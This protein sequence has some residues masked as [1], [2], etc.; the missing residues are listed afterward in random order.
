MHGADLYSNT[1]FTN[2]TCGIDLPN[3]SHGRYRLLKKISEDSGD[4]RA[5][6]IFYAAEQHCLL[7]TGGL[8]FVEAA[9][10]WCYKSV[11]YYGS[12]IFLPVLWLAA[13]QLL[14]PFLFLNAEPS[15]ALPLY[16]IV[17][18]SIAYL[19]V[20]A[21][22]LT[23][24]VG[25]SRLMDIGAGLL[26]AVAAML[27]AFSLK[28]FSWGNYWDRSLMLL[29]NL[30]RP[31]Y[32]WEHEARPGIHYLFGLMHLTTMYSAFA[33]FIFAIRRRFKME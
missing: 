2:I 26:L 19:M 27:V 1:D 29:R 32:G 16:A 21:L 3:R 11:S 23:K 28:E 22:W 25:P 10:S 13:L 33:M 14:F 20:S 8:P 5:A 9:I 6:S 7:E 15:S 12:R 31:F 30:F 17:S 18:L 24:K 4:Y